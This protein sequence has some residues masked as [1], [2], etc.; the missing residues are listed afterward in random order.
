MQREN[1]GFRPR[2]NWL[3]LGVLLLGLGPA[4][5]ASAALLQG[6]ILHGLSGQ[7]LPG[8][9][10]AVAGTDLRAESDPEG[11]VRLDVPEGS[12]DLEV[13]K[14]EFESQRVVGVVVSARGGQFAVVLTP[15]AGTDAEL[16][17]AAAISE[18]ITVAAEASAVTEAA[19]LAERRNATQISDS[20][21]AEEM[22]KNTGSDAAAAL[23][24]VTGVSLQDDKYV[25]VRGL[26]E[27]YS[28]TLLN[29]SKISSTEFE[30]KVVPLDLF[31]ADFL[32][33]VTV[34][35]S[36]TAD[37]PGDFAAGF[38]ELETVEFP[39]RRRLTVG[40]S[41]GE[42]SVTTGE[43][44]L[45]YGSGL[46]SSGNGGQ[47]LGA[48]IPD[49]PLIRASRFNPSGFTPE[50][51][52]G[53]GEQLVGLWSPDGRGDAPYDRGFNLSYGE[54]I[55]RVGLV[56]AAT[57]DQSSVVRSEERNIFGVAPDG[58]GVE[59]INLFD[60]TYGE[61]SIKQGLIGN[62]SLRLSDNHRIQLRSLYTKNSATEARE[63]AGFFIDQSDNLQD[64]R[65][66]YLEQEITN[67]QLSGDHYFAS[68]DGATVEWRVATSE[69]ATVENRR[70]TNYRET[71]PGSGVFELTDNAQS[72]FMY[73]NELDDEVTDAALSGSLYLL[74]ERFATEWEIGGAWTSNDRNF[75]GRRLRF[76]HRN[77]FGVD[78]T[79]APELLFTPELIGPVFE[80]EEITR[81]TDTY[82]G[83]QEVVAGYLQTDVAAGRWRAVLGL[84]F[85]DSQLDVVTLD[86]T[87]PAFTPIVSSVD[88]SDL[89]P[90]VSLIYRLSDAANARIGASR[91]VNRPEFRELA[92]FRYTHIV[93]GYAVTGNPELVSATIDSFDL[94]WEWFPSAREVVAASV[95]YKRF[96]DPIESVVVAGAEL[97]ETYLNAE[98]AEN[99]GVEVELRRSFGSLAGSLAGWTGIL[100]ATWVDSEISIDPTS[101]ILTNPTRP[102]NGQ[103]DLVV[104]AVLEWSAANAGT[105]FRLLWNRTGE[106]VALGG[107]LGVPDVVEAERDSLDVVL[108]QSLDRFVP[109]LAVKLSGSNLTEEER[110][111]TQGG[112]TFRRYEPGRALG[113]SVSWSSP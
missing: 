42:N 99:L 35:K 18:S 1:S 103:P 39:P 11:R 111:W 62:L 53:I 81:A 49:R 78:L 96:T 32:D 89:L 51:L 104:N 79:Q 82:E 93:G 100:N 67:A 37:K 91:T 86:R 28:N 36:Y 75:D 38:V 26:G 102:L 7:P 105:T 25:F 71:F 69:A 14:S 30:R 83:E 110:L 97:L 31:P 17:G 12:L 59:A 13:T 24:R 98:K 94:R 34:S 45:S 84:R 101:T 27:R 63:Q 55:G 40:V 44:L 15:L 3:A 68:G 66:S 33:K 2:C 76:S 92:P 47:P 74:G 41:G 50:E 108:R 57:Y 107:A 6:Q 60:F 9:T 16:A 22:S 19:L 80:V 70:E 87:N 88:D 85:E 20:I 90:S 5:P 61:E 73:F 64:F 54:T 4:Q 8:A 106:K 77:T 21:G 113:L 52:E 48:G 29:G 112:G 56:L 43:P 72:G 65:L 10:V 46:S 95:F 23:Q 58:N 109:G